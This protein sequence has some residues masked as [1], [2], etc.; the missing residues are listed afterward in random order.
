[1]GNKVQ[2]HLLFKWL[3]NMHAAMSAPLLPLNFSFPPQPEIT[4]RKWK[5]TF[6]NFYY[7]TLL[8]YSKKKIYK[9]I[10]FSLISYNFYILFI[11][12]IIIDIFIQIHYYS[13]IIN[14][15]L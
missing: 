3:M 9:E 7:N 6:Y 4:C 1:M 5:S 13:T 15:T 2:F 8:L 10:N 12:N 14:L 11:T